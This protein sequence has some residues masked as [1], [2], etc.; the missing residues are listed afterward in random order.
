MAGQAY[1]RSFG[2][3]LVFG[4]RPATDAPPSPEGWT[5]EV[6]EE[7]GEHDFV[8]V[9]TPP[10][11]FANPRD[12][13]TSYGMGA[14]EVIEWDRRS[15]GFVTGEEEY[16]AL[17]EVVSKLLWSGSDTTAAAQDSARV[18][19]R[20]MIERAGSG[21]LRIV[22]AEV[23]GPEPGRPLG[24]IERIAFTVELCPAGSGPQDP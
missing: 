4:L 18:H 10:Y 22:D 14:R 16:Q 9:A 23:A 15:F 24:R 7:R 20:G 17:A 1:E 6:R 8:W 3:G 13:T 12:L 5:I 21:E 19:W 2:A 11:R